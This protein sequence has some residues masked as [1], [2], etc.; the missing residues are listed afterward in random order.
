MAISRYR[1]T[2]GSLAVIASLALGLT[3]CQ[4]LSGLVDTATTSDPANSGQMDPETATDSTEETDTSVPQVEENTD[5]TTQTSPV[6]QAVPRCGELYSP[7]QVASFEQEGRQSEGDIS[8]DGYGY[9]TT[10]VDLVGI[11][12]GVRADLRVSCTWYLPP[13]FSSTTSVAILSSEAMAGVED[14]LNQTSNT[15]AGLGGGTLWTI[16]T[17]SSNISGEY[18]ANEAH[19]ITPTECPESLAESSCAV[20]FA[21]TNSSGS[22]EEL[23]RDAADV[24]GALD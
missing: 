3:G 23:T 20:W 8:Q 10:D 5:D 9:G 11:L 14:I 21:S 15:Q 2:V 16:D 24:F 12:E 17:S 18:I 1:T 7:D 13:E 6:A 19:F 4:A 22:A